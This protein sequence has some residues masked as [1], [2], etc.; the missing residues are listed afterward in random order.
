MSSRFDGECRGTSTAVGPNEGIGG[1]SYNR[2]QWDGRQRQLEN[3]CRATNGEWTAHREPNFNVPLAQILTSA[4]DGTCTQPPPTVTEIGGNV[5]FTNETGG[6]F[7]FDAQGNRRPVG[8]SGSRDTGNVV[9]NINAPTYGADDLM[10]MVE[11]GVN[12]GMANGN[13]G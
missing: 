2:A 10:D 7:Y 6:G 4:F 12:E 1:S 8:G 3:Q 11:Q 9:V 13:I 5:V